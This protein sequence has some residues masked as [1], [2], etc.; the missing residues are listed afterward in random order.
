[1]NA[2]DDADEASRLFDSDAARDPWMRLTERLIADFPHVDVALVTREI[3]EARQRVHRFGLK[4]PESIDIV[5]VVV[6]R[7]LSQPSDE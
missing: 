7:R 1:M 4:P 5:S 3:D 6:H 2:E